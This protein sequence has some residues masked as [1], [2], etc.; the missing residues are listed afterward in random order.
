MLIM[1]QSPGVFSSSLK[2]NNFP[3]IVS[4]LPQQSVAEGWN[5]VV[6]AVAVA[7]I[8]VLVVPSFTRAWGL[9][10]KWPL[11]GTL[12]L[13]DYLHPSGAALIHV[14]VLMSACRIAETFSPEG[15]RRP[16]VVAGKAIK[17]R[18]S[19]CRASLCRRSAGWFINW[20]GGFQS[21]TIKIQESNWKSSFCIILKV[22]HC[23][24][25]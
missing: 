4:S 6:A 12:G 7:A 1:F 17:T 20:L 16:W 3:H 9:H 22:L 18:N 24:K 13:L 23:F 8:V 15:H 25:N 11:L 21:S 10:R 5:L 19:S 14:A 2:R